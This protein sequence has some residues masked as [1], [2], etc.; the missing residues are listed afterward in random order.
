MI[1]FLFSDPVGPGPESVGEGEEYQRK[2]EPREYP[3]D[4]ARDG[5][6]GQLPQRTFFQP[7]VELF[8]RRQGVVAP[9]ADDD[10]VVEE[11]QTRV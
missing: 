3:E 10:A 1:S 5:L 8:F 9:F 2:H 7:A 11:Q 6:G 4:L